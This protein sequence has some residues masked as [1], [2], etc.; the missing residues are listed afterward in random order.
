MHHYHVLYP[1]ELNNNTAGMT[2]TALISE[3]SI[4]SYTVSSTSKALECTCCCIK[5]KFTVLWR[6]Y[7]SDCFL[8]TISNFLGSLLVA[9]QLLRVE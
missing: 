9:R 6:A 5:C 2:D 3:R 8:A 4:K 1:D 7:V